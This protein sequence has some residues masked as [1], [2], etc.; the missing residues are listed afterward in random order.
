MNSKAWLSFTAVVLLFSLAFSWH[1]YEPALAQSEDIVWSEVINISNSPGV[2][3]SD[4]FLLADPAGIMHLFWTEKVGIAPGN[5]PDTVLYSQWNG[6]TWSKVTDL[7]FA[8]LSD[9]NLLVSYPHAILDSAGI[10]HLIWLSQPNF[11]Y[12]TLYYSSA[13]A[14]Q[15]QFVQA[16]QPK[17]A[18]AE[19]LNGT[20]YSIHLAYEEPNTVHVMYASGVQSDRALEEPGVKYLSSADGGVTWTEPATVFSVRNPTDGASD[21][22][23]VYSA[24][25]MLFASWT[26]WAADGN[27]RAIYFSRSLD[28]GANWDDPKVLDQRREGE[29][30]RD[31]NSLAVLPDG[32]LMAMWEGG[33]RAYRHA[34]FSTDQGATW[35]EPWDIFPRLIGENGF[36]EFATDSNGVLHLF[37]SQRL[38]E[39]S[40]EASEETV[41]GLWHSVYLGDG[42]W[43]DPTL[44]GGINAILNPKVSIVNGNTVM[45]AWY[46]SSNN[47]YEIRLMTGTI[48]GAPQVQPIPWPK[49][50]QVLRNT[51]V[52]MVE[53][54]QAEPTPTA[55]PV[56]ALNAPA[57][58]PSGLL[59]N[60]GVGVF[61]G[62][63]PV[64]LLLPLFF[65]TQKLR[66]KE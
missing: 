33:Y 55:A 35:T 56:V 50:T 41:S 19:D 57:E 26:M 2:T 10:I 16:W 47:D 21:V 11:P 48:L 53:V 6:R 61:L 1:I 14:S 8:P 28:G 30:E 37:Y 7:F 44:S 36:V 49:D 29:Y 46:T 24:P 59:A 9:G 58:N 31:W 62:A 52:A 17:V 12:Y 60:P 39:G 32:M 38:R 51:P 40:A 18:L 13:P 5:Q 65:L 25:D 45:A 42:Q 54:A 3:S 66:R 23:V 4:P 63:L 15:A 22:R 27:G 64:L 34:M 20:K 43:S